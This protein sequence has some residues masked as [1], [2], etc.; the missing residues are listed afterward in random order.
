IIVANRWDR[1]IEAYKDKV[2]TRE[3]WIR[4]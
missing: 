4:D 1:G 3:I 2:Y